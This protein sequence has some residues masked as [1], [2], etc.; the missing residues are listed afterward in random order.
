MGIERVQLM[1]ARPSSNHDFQGCPGYRCPPTTIGGRERV[2]DCVR[3]SYA[4]NLDGKRIGCM[5]FSGHRMVAGE[6]RRVRKG[7][8]SP[9]TK[10]RGYPFLPRWTDWEG[11]RGLGLV[12]GESKCYKCGRGPW[13][14]GDRWVRTGVFTYLLT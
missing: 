6:L 7:W 2:E 1:D 9:R 5:G 8:C 4:P 11:L 10:Q 3:G 12:S 14:R 13:D